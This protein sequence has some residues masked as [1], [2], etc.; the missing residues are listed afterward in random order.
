MAVAITLE[1]ELYA[2]SLI[3]YAN[4]ELFMYKY[5]VACMPALVFALV[6]WQIKAHIQPHTCA[7]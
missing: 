2:H 5:M 1:L 7:L 3:L 4:E 6:Y